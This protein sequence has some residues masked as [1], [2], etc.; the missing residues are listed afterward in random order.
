MQYTVTRGA[1]LLLTIDL[2][3]FGNLSQVEPLH[4]FFGCGDVNNG[5][6][7]YEILGLGQTGYTIFDEL[8]LNDK[9]FSFLLTLFW[10]TTLIFVSF[11]VSFIS[12][13]SAFYTHYILRG[14]M[15][16]T[17]ITFRDGIRENRLTQIVRFWTTIFFFFTSF[18]SFNRFLHDFNFSPLDNFIYV[19]N[20]IK[21]YW[22]L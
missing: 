7:A 4:A 8:N 22:F 20:R 12:Y 17:L 6:E 1:S 2:I 11:S 18:F 10:R 3:S 21:A 19:I 9:F 16:S 5:E 13:Y 14:F 15:H